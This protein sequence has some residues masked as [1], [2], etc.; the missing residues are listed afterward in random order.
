MTQLKISIIIPVYN[1]ENYLEECL[2]SV[3]SQDYPAL[4]IIAIDDGSTDRSS[5]ILRDFESKHHNVK[6]ISTPNRGQSSARNEGLKIAKGDFIL[7]LDAD[8]MI[9]RHAL[10]HCVRNIDIYRA[11]ILFFG[12]SAF[13]DSMELGTLQNFNYERSPY[14]VNRTICSHAFFAL[15]IKLNNYIVSPCLYIYNRRKLANVKFYPGIIHE[16]NLF[17]TQLLLENKRLQV[18]CIGDKLF[19]RRIRPNSTMTQKKRPEHI[20]GYMKV[21]AE[22]LKTSLIRSNNEAGKALNYFIQNMIVN[23]L[24]TCQSVHNNRFPLEIRKRAISLIKQIDFRSLSLAKLAICVL[25]ELL[26]LR[27]LIKSRP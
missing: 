7:F 2:E 16:D 4:E 24:A 9:E 15:S 3:T 10:S 20:D 5:E 18:A 19:R 25:P 26:S 12:A 11:D 17:T 1:V 6:I 27:K 22:L 13:C 14:I 21:A 23:S 8:D